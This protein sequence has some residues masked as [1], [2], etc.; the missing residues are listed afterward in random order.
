M[1]PTRQDENG[2]LVVKPGMVFTIKPRFVIPGVAR[3]SA[4]FGDPVLIT[5]T[6]AERLGVRKPEVITLGV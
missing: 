4:Q 5:Q 3:P 6:G 2:E 1:G